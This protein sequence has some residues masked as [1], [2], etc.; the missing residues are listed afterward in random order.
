MV[1]CLSLKNDVMVF[2]RN[3][4][5]ESLAPE[6][7]GIPLSCLLKFPAKLKKAGQFFFLFSEPM[8]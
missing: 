2:L 8:L 1:V 7:F 6:I 5:W 4:N 3:T